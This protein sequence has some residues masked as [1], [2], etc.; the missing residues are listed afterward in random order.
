MS[1]SLPSILKSIGLATALSFSAACAAYPPAANAQGDVGTN[2]PVL[3]M[4]E[5]EDPNSVKRSSDIFKRVVAE[6][7]GAMQRHGFRMIDEESV[8]VDLGWEIAD[9]RPKSELIES[10]KLMGKSDNAAHQVRAWVLVRIHAQA[11]ELSFST[12]VQTRDRRR[13]LRCPPRTSSSTRLKCPA[14]SIRRPRIAWNPPS[15][16]A[17]WWATGRATSRAGWAKCWPA[18]WPAT[19]R[20]AKPTPEPTLQATWSAEATATC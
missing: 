11:K 7:Q 15:A 5:D 18:S 14:R 4:S 19:P 12:K 20:R 13:D 6:L 10:V 9:R 1:Q 3:V 16:S 17:R 2:I 8:A